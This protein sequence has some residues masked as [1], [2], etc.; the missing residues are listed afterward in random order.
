MPPAC[1]ILHGDVSNILI[2]S[3]PTVSEPQTGFDVG[4]A[5]I[6]VAN[7]LIQ[8]EGSLDLA[9]ESL[10]VVRNAEWTTELDKLGNF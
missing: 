6:F 4:S 1:S 8:A 2:T 9:L 10:G 5:T 3:G 7:E